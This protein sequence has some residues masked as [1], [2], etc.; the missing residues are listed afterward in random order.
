[1]VVMTVMIMF[2]VYML[3]NAIFFRE[4]VMPCMI[5]SQNIQSLIERFI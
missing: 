4:I 2:G 3:M 5:V 1:M